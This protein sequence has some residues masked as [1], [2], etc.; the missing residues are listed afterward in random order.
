[1]PAERGS[2][3]EFIERANRAAE[4]VRAD[5]DPQVLLAQIKEREANERY[6]GM[7]LAAAAEAGAGV[8]RSIKIG[9]Q[10]ERRV[11]TTTFD[12]I[13]FDAYLTAAVKFLKTGRAS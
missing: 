2:P 12:P 5:N 3:E 8:G 9:N 1:M 7:A 13:Q 4:K 10:Y 6:R 11:E